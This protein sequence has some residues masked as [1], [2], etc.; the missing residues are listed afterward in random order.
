VQLLYYDPQVFDII[1]QESQMACVQAQIGHPGAHLTNAREHPAIASYR[2][3][4]IFGKETLI[5]LFLE[6]FGQGLGLGIVW[7]NSQ[8][9]R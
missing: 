7:I 4:Q 1:E 8:H 5:E 3:T 2:K 6:A 9:R